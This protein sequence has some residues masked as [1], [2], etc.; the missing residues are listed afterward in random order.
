VFLFVV[1]DPQ[2]RQYLNTADSRHSTACAVSEGCRNF[3]LWFSQWRTE[4]ALREV[5][6]RHIRLTVKV[7]CTDTLL[8]NKDGRVDL[9]PVSMWI[10]IFFK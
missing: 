3:D 7:L 9:L 6:E 10:F 4:A 2:V 1:V 5:A 8:K